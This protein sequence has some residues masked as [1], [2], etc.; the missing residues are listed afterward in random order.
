M[1]PIFRVVANGIDITAKIADRLLTLT[2]EDKAGITS[3][4]VEIRID[5]RD[6]A[7]ATPPHGAGLQV[8]LGYQETGL[9]FLGH[10]TVCETE[11]GGKPD[12]L[13]VKAEACDMRAAI[14]APKTRSWHDVTIGDLVG[15][16]AAEHGLTPAVATDLRATSLG[17]IDQT[18]ESDLHL[19]TRLSHDH[20]AVASVKNGNLLFGCRGAGTSVTGQPLSALAVKG[21]E[22]A[23]WTMVAQDRG[24]YGVVEA[25]WRDQ[26][27]NA[28]AAERAGDGAGPVYKLRGEY[29]SAAAAQAAAQSR[30]GRL[31]RG[32]ATLTVTLRVGRPEAVAEAPLTLSSLHPDA[33]GGWSITS[34]FHTFDGSGLSTSIEAETPP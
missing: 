13:T 17:H 19:L 6:L 24:K 21:D 22:V 16:I 11:I 30:L 15:A 28:L 25:T 27:A 29:P 7:V 26:A 18:E 10:Y 34:V 9:V 1:R 23:S 20:D 12:Y 32:E 33:D 8:W 4:T 3:D 2:V 5:N 31:A 14:R